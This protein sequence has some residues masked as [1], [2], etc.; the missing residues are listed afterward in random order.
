MS[1]PCIHRMI[2]ISSAHITTDTWQALEEEVRWPKAFDGITVY[3]KEVYGFFLYLTNTSMSIPQKY[4]DLSRIV[5]YALKN[6]CDAICIDRDV[7]PYDD[8][9]VVN[10][11]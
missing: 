5:N 11:D 10:N 8:L 6:D 9:E 3:E 2:D 1:K 4:P 7:A